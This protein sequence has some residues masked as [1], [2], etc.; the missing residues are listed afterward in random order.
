MKIDGLYRWGIALLCASIISPLF[1]SPAAAG[2]MEGIAPGGQ[3][4]A[5]PIEQK[6]VA[7]DLYFLYDDASSN[8]AFLVTD[9]GVLVVDT[10]Q[11]PR[12]G[13][14]LVERIRKVTDKPIRWAIV[15]HFHG[16]HHMGSPA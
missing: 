11:H 6:K 5:P 16:D 12:H 13:Q 15:T 3:R 2:H 9:E 10:R 4:V 8:S 1:A 7:P 14:D